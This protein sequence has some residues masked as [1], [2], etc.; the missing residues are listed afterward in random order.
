M[1]MST[2]TLVEDVYVI[3]ILNRAD[4]RHKRGRMLVGA[5]EI[6]SALVLS[7]ENHAF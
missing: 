3:S 5:R 1:K 4:T 7:L 2:C 6:Y